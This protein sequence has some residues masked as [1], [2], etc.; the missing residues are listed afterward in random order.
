MWTL[1][2][3]LDGYYI[4]PGT[5][6][7]GGVASGGNLVK[8]R[9][10]NSGVG[11]FDVCCT[12]AVSTIVEAGD[13]TVADVPAGVVF[14]GPSGGTCE[15]DCFITNLANCK[16]ALVELDIDYTGEWTIS[17]TTYV[18]GCSYKH[19][20][21]NMLHFNSNINGVSRHSETPVCRCR[22]E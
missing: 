9:S 18:Y 14:A 22:T 7:C 11:M 19:V 13:A 3:S 20:E 16:Q 6:N 5:E 1:T 12:G 17:E 4:R 2:S 21:N 8:S 10:S 15:T